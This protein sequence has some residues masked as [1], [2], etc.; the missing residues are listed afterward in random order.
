MIVMFVSPIGKK[1]PLLFDTFVDTF[2]KNGIFITD[3]INEADIVFYD[4]YS[5]LGEHD[6]NTID[7]ILERKMPVVIFDETDYGGMSKNNWDAG[8]VVFYENGNPIMY[9]MRKM[10]KEKSYP[11]WVKPYE[12]IQY[13]SHD[14]P[15]TTKEELFS[16][17]TDICWIGNTSPTRANL[18]TGLLKYKTFTIDC[19]FT[20]ERIPHEE[21]LNRHRKAKLF[22]S[23]CGGGFSDER[24]YQLITIAPMLRN[25]SQQLKINDFEDMQDCIEINEIPTEQDVSKILSVL[26]DAD[27]LYDIYMR[28]I[29]RMRNFYN[30]IY[31][32]NYILE[33]LKE[34]NII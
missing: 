11:D 16:R 2:T 25:K 24:A 9:F 34:N 3:N 32:A 28:G 31:R 21:W 23:A 4:H 18:L 29:E 10:S 19:L 12:L 13:P 22:I 33:T 30:P 14:F 17:D 26:N 27:L 15:P 6:S 8:N 5:G 20:K 7:C 1:T